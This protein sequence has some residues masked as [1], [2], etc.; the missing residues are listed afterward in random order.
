MQKKFLQR[1][2]MSGGGFAAFLFFIISC[3][4]PV[5][6]NPNDKNGVAKTDTFTVVFNSNEGTAVDTQFVPEGGKVA[7][8]PAPVRIG[9]TFAG[10]YSDSGLTAIPATIWV[11]PRSWPISII[12]SASEQAPLA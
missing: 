2:I 5:R 12:H 1:L 8:P 11:T 10:W 7:E 9:Y 6:D 3:A 4:N